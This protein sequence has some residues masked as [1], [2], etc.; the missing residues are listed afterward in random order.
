MGHRGALAGRALPFRRQP[1]HDVERRIF[2]ALHNAER[3]RVRF[4]CKVIQFL[5]SFGAGVFQ[6]LY[7]VE[8]VLTYGFIGVIHSGLFYTSGREG[9]LP[10]A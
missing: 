3:V 8:H 7:A 9:G 6:L 1:A 10:G 4:G 5:L 2:P